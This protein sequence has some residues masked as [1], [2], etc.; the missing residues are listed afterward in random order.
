MSTIKRYFWYSQNKYK[1]TK[2]CKLLVEK[3]NLCSKIVDMHWY[4]ILVNR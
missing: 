4:F 1:P 2:V 3:N